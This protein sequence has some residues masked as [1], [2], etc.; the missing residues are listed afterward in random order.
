MSAEPKSKLREWREGRGYSL[1]HV[2]DLIKDRGL[3]RPSAAKLSRIERKQNI[4]SEMV[5]I[6]AAITDIPAKEL[7][8]DLAKI[9]DGV[10]Q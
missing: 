9:F 5:P 6:I 7:R 10:D 4:P 2:C 1:D 8:P 3:G